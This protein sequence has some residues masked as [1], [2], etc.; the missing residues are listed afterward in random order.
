MEPVSPTGVE[1]GVA[2]SHMNRFPIAAGNCV[3][4]YC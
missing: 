2:S 4:E 3:K 1:E